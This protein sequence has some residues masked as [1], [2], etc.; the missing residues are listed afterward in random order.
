MKGI[1]TFATQAEG[2]QYF[3]SLVTYVASR[4]WFDTDEVKNIFRREVESWNPKSDD[5][6][7]QFWGLVC[8]PVLQ[9][10]DGA[11]QGG[12]DTTYSDFWWSLPNRP[13]KGVLVGAV[14]WH[15][16]ATQG[17]FV[18]L[19]FGEDGSCRMFYDTGYFLETGLPKGP[20]TLLEMPKEGDEDF[21]AMSAEEF[22]ALAF[23]PE[24]RFIPMSYEELS[25]GLH[26][27][28]GVGS[29]YRGST[30]EKLLQ[31]I[32]KALPESLSDEEREK[33]SEGACEKAVFSLLAGVTTQEE[34]L[35]KIWVILH[36]ELG[37]SD[38]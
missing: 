22:K 3:V 12:D 23:P 13:K 37:E 34:A 1:H 21:S 11:R 18:R 9:F 27:L 30:A 4:G 24:P 17:R 32:A 20:S 7:A 38:V 29:A 16:T 33:L 28:L 14:G 6:V 36:P 8:L 15:G 26:G 25:R 35:A 31:Q 5:G 10:F 2:L 19:V